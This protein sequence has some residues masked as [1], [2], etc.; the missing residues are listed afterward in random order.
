MI[1]RGVGLLEVVFFIK[2][3]NYIN[4]KRKYTEVF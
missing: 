3:N 1:N 4:I 2:Y